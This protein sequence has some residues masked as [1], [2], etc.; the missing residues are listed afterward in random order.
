MDFV[1]PGLLGTPN[2][3]CNRFVNPITNGQYCNSTSEDVRLMKERA[4]VLHTLLGSSVQRLDYSV[5]K[6]YLPA[7]HE[8]VIKKRLT[9]LQ[10]QLYHCCLKR[11]IE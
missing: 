8:Y 9:S 5:I 11:E 7:K 6:P 10:K 1:K 4:Y 3:F 2:E